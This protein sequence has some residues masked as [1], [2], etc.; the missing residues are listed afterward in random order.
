MNSRVIWLCLL[1]VSI[2]PTLADTGCVSCQ[3]AVALESWSP[4]KH[5]RAVVSGRNCGATTWYTTEVSLVKPSESLPSRGNIASLDDG[6]R[7]VALPM[8]SEGALRVRI[9]WE[10]ENR[11]QVTYPRG[12]LMRKQLTNFKE[13]T[14]QY[15]PRSHGPTLLQLGLGQ[16]LYPRI[17]ARE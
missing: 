12:A 17:R 4:G 2:A 6:N 9:V 15:R 7:S 13:V 14:I 16:F 8:G 10:A 1:Y 5:W 3:N 11:L